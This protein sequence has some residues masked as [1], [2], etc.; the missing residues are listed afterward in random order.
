[1]HENPVRKGFV[2][3]PEHWKYS[4]ARNWMLH[5]D[6]II[7]IDKEVLGIRVEPSSYMVADVGCQDDRVKNFGE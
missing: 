1:M 3:L 4:S 2:E 6:S 7:R 5:D